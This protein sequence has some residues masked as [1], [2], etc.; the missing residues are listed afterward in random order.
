MPKLVVG[1]L[2]RPEHHRPLPTVS[3]PIRGA[4]GTPLPGAFAIKPMCESTPSRFELFAE[5]FVRTYWATVKSGDF[6]MPP[7]EP[8]EE[9]LEELLSDIL[10]ETTLSPS[11]DRCGLT[12]EL[13]M[14]SRH[15]DWWLFQ[16]REIESQWTLQKASAAS[17]SH[18]PHDL[19]GPDYAADF[20]P[21]LRHIERLANVVTGDD[22]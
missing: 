8:V 7:D 22:Q 12:G 18:Q 19:L 2:L 15:G 1:M 11:S 13:R 9:T 14:T 17:D 10:R 5:A 6:P 21:F 16:F 4:T 20:K 3:A